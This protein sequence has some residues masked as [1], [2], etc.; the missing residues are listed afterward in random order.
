MKTLLILGCILFAFE[1]SA[2][3]MKRTSSLRGAENCSEF[4]LMHEFGPTRS[5]GNMGW[6][7]A[8][9]SA[10]LLGFEF[11]EQLD[12]QRVSAIQIALGFNDLF[13][14]GAK[15]EG[16]LAS[17]A[18][19]MA[20]VRG[21]CPQKIED[22]VLLQGPQLPLKK[23]IDGLIYLKQNFDRTKGASLESDLKAYYSPNKSFLTQI[24]IEDLR[25]LLA[26]SKERDFVSNFADYT[27]RGQK[28]FPTPK[29]LAIG[30]S[31]YPLLGRTDPLM[32]KIHERMD[33]HKPVIIDYFADL[34][35][36]DFARKLNE[37]RHTSIVIGRR[38]NDETN[39]CEVLIRNSWGKRCDLY[40]AESLK[41]KC[42]DGNIWVSDEKLKKYIFGIAYFM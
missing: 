33:K 5:Q 17:I 16:G 36:A 25:G 23:K 8:N 40:K 21:F 27:C 4:D 11:R 12:G 13:F 42:I 41:K 34:F 28:F 18:L 10:D 1:A 9:A 31:K 19:N 26:N 15:G 6:C 3:G 20:Q 22:E 37:S 35:D 38:W 39:K 24:P 2:D 7:Y 32:T 14:Q 30:V 29:H